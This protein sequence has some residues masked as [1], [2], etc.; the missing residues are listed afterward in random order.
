MTD[1]E[2]LDE[3]VRA[4]ERTLTDGDVTLPEI[5]SGADLAE[6]VDELESRTEGVERRLDELDAATQA[7]RGY[8]GSVRSVNREVERRADA[9]LAAVESMEREREP[10]PEP[11]AI[12]GG[13]ASSASDAGDGGEPT[14]RPEDG[15]PD[16]VLARVRGAL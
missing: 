13:S 16:G 10:I 15:E 9:A 1:A 3:R 2:A 12:P 8:V 11:E 4:I 14:T 6:R 7:L 5:E